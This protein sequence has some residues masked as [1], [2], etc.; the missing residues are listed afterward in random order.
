MVNMIKNSPR[1]KS[2]AVRVQTRRA[3]SRRTA[4][5]SRRKLLDLTGIELY[6]VMSY[7][8]ALAVIILIA[9]LHLKGQ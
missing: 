3:T 5:R 8:L 4:S 7:R 1:P 2:G 6:A 9:V